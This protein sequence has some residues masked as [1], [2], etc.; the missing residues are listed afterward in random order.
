MGDLDSALR[1]DPKRAPA[2][3]LRCRAYTWR[4]RGNP[5]PEHDI[6]RAIEDATLAAEL[7]PRSPLALILRGHARLVLL[8]TSDDAGILAKALSDFDRAAEIDA[9]CVDAYLG[10]AE[11]WWIFAA[12]RLSK[13][14]DA[15]KGCQAS[16]QDATRALELNPKCAQAWILRGHAR[17]MAGDKAA[18]IA[19]Y[20]AAI[21]IDSRLE[22]SLRATID[23]LRK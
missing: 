8:G 19:D 22:G 20:E 13:G 14:E 15:V 7:E 10:R 5:K 23:K 6:Q 18:A 11:A 2:L 17:V 1:L 9:K 3:R 21:R 12:N 16:I 4:A